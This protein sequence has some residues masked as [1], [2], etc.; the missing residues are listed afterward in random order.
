MAHPSFHF[1]ENI[2]RKKAASF[3][4]FVSCV[5]DAAFFFSFFLKYNRYVCFLSFSEIRQ[6]WVV[7]GN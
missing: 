1:A 7:M 2:G 5:Q 4:K 6:T 3:L